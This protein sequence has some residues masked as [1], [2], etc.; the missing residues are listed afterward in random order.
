MPIFNLIVQNAFDHSRLG[1]VTAS[2][3]LFRQI[4]ATVGVAIM[5]SVLNN[6]LTRHLESLANDPSTKQLAA[7]TGKA[8][9][10][11]HVNANQL[12]GL[13]S[14]QAQH[15]AT[16]HIANIS[17]EKQQG[18]LSAYQ[19][20]ITGLKTALSSSISEVFIIAGVLVSI[21][22]V[23]SFFLKEIPLRTSNDHKD[24]PLVTE[25][26]APGGGPS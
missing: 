24:H 11:S 1:V 13:L 20:F 4:G 7:G 5:G 18:I 22:F 6:G 21:A 2:V 12:Q 16:S 25:G 19:H 14:P 3:Q 23:A 8:L 9:D 17:P 15:A 26:G 10:V